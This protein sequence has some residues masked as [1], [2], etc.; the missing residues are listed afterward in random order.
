MRAK[1]E[2]HRLV[3]R[4]ASEGIAVLVSSSEAPELLDL[5]DRIIVMAQGRSVDVVEAADASE[6]ALLRLAS[7]PGLE[8]PSS[9]REEWSQST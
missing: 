1:A 3:R 8:A 9:N 6:E 5:C 2:I 4:I 7:A